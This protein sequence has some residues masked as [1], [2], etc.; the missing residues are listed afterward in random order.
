MDRNIILGVLID[1]N[2]KV[3]RFIPLTLGTLAIMVLFYLMPNT[4]LELLA[5]AYGILTIM[6]LWLIIIHIIFTSLAYGIGFYQ[7]VKQ[8]TRNNNE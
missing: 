1:D 3:A 6:A 8:W 2:G 7:Q 5:R 4:M